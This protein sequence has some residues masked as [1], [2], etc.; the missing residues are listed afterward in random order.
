MD[1]PNDCIAGKTWGQCDFSSAEWARPEI[2]FVSVTGPHRRLDRAGRR[3]EGWRGFLN[4]WEEFG[5]EP[6]QYRGLDDERVLALVHLSG[7][8][9]TS[10]LEL[11]Q[12]R[13]KGAAALFERIGPGETGPIPLDLNR[14][15]LM[16]IT[17]LMSSVA[18]PP[19]L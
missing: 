12:M 7:R 18:V 6:D 19:E 13:G 16:R 9:K 8:G 14:D 10:G 17:K 2:E 5:I 15:Q 3:G 11:G 1:G 4:A